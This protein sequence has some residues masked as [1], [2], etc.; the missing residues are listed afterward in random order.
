MAHDLTHVG[1]D[2]VG[3]D[4]T[5]VGTDLTLWHMTS[6]TWVLKHAALYGVP[7]LHAAPFPFRTYMLHV[8]WSLLEGSDGRALG[9]WGLGGRLMWH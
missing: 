6:P 5:H 4:L 8:W 3:T 7:Y 2:H 9:L 1:T